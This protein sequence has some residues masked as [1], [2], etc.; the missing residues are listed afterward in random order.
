[1]DRDDSQERSGLRNEE[2]WGGTAW[3]VGKEEFENPL[4]IYQQ[5]ICREEAQIHCVKLSDSPKYLAHGKRSRLSM[6]RLIS[7]VL[8]SIPKKQSQQE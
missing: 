7:M 3:E 4:L 5:H 1:M 8:G 2:G 6:V